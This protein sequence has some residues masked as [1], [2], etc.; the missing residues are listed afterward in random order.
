MNDRIRNLVQQIYDLQ[1]EL[2]TIL[3]EQ[4]TRAFFE[5]AG[6]RIRFQRAVK[7][8]HQQLKI[9]LFHW[10]RTSRPQSILSAPI[11]YGIFL[12]MLV[13]DIALTVYQ[14]TCF[15]LYGIPR[16]Q[17]SKYIVIDRHRLAYLNIFEKLNCVYCGYA[18]GLIAYAREIAACTE[19]Y[20]CPIK[21]ARKVL[22]SHDRYADF[23]D[24]GDAGEYHKKL[25]KLRKALSDQE[26]AGYHGQNQ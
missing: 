23:L 5:I 25:E 1:E 13:Y 24:Y 17:R 18:N 10:F 4:E 8:T 20:W 22:G 6:K 16:V 14:A 3:H 11:I 26:Q 19:Q 7:E 9:G 15:R 2:R 12:P 21:H